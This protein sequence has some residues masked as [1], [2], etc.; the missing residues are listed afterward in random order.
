MHKILRYLLPGFFIIFTLSAY[1]FRTATAPSE[2]QSADAVF[3]QAAETIIAGITLT[4]EA[5]AAAAAAQ[6]PVPEQSDPEQAEDT[7]DQEAPTVTPSPTTEGQ[8]DMDVLPS[9]TPTATEEGLPSISATVGTN[10]RFGPDPAHPILGYLLEGETSEVHGKDKFGF[11]WYI[12]NPDVPGGFCWV[13]TETTIVEG[14]TDDLPYIE[15]PPTPTPTPTDTPTTTP[16]ATATD[17]GYP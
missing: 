5:D 1:N 7:A 8:T 3:T 14:N 16:T 17:D 11:W 4:V 10:C 6:Q 2:D 15:P 9:D 12:A 13:W